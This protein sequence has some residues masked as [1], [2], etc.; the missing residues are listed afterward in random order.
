[1]PIAK[2]VVQ[3]IVIAQMNVAIAV[4]AGR[5]R[6]AIQSRSGQSEPIASSV[7]Q[8][9]LGKKTSNAHTRDTIAS[10]KTPSAI[11]PRGGKLRAND[12]SPIARGATAMFPIASDEN[13]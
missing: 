12:A 4:I 1:M 6:D 3:T 11:S 7:V 9:S 10:A 2:I 8:G 13:Q 5:R